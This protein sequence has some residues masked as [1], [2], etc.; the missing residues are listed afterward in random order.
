MIRSWLATPRNRRIFILLFIGVISLLIRALAHYDFDRSALLYIGVPYL[1]A[2]ALMFVDT[3]NDGTNWK[4][5]YFNAAIRS[6]VIMLGSSIILFEGFLCVVMFMPIYFLVILLAFLFEALGR[7]HSKKTMGKTHVHVLPLLIIVGALEGVT[8]SLSF[9]RQYSI[10][11]EKVINAS[12]EQIKHQLTK[13]MDLQKSR[14][15]LLALFPMPYNI[16]AGTLKAGDIH[17]IDLRYH[18]WFVTNTH[19]GSMR[20]QLDKVTDT[21]IHTSFIQDN[22]YIS[23][24]M[25]LHGTHLKFTSIT[26]TKT[27]V[28][29]TIKYQR[30]LDPS[31]YFGPLQ[32][33]AIGKS[34]LFLLD[35]VITPKH[36]LFNK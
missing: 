25:K 32:E 9:D 36:S 12:V 14:A 8:P 20:L 5:T 7:Y 27:K 1:V 4:K 18:R 10:T 34:A 29:L 19:Q 3:S 30:L 28:S 23:N 21:D 35:E 22:S 24:Y 31:W 15:W 16:E 17:T 6:L 13:P 2:I 11:R 33:Y 26:P